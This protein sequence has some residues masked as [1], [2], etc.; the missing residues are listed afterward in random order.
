MLYSIILPYKKEAPP[1]Q[2]REGGAPIFR[3]FN[4][5][6]LVLWGWHRWHFFF[7]LW[8]VRNQDGCG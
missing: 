6:F 2:G 8:N 1:S 5:K 7:L 4:P 3:L